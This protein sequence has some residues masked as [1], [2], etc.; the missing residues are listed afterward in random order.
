MEEQ[1]IHKDILIADLLKHWPTLVPFFLE[2]KMDCVGCSLMRF[3]TVADAVVAYDLELDDFIM[4]LNAQV[5]AQDD[6]NRSTGK[7]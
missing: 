7:G 6:E 2:Q 5:Q 1:R 4:A 3:C